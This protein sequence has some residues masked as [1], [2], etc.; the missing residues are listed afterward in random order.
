MKNP[1]VTIGVDPAAPNGDHS[2]KAV[3]QGNQVQS[4]VYDEFEIDLVP[5]EPNVVT[6]GAFPKI[7]DFLDEL[8]N[9]DYV[10]PQ[11]MYYATHHL[12][13][14]DNEVLTIYLSKT[15]VDTIVIKKES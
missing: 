6:R 11:D 7:Y 9:N 15:G 2:A 4:I 13:T 3:I 14:S 5:N 1:P 8:V 10:K 12:V